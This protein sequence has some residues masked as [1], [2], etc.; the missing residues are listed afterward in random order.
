MKFKCWIENVDENTFFL[1]L[2]NVAKTKQWIALNRREAREFWENDGDLVDR[3]KIESPTELHKVQL[4]IPVDHV[5]G[6]KSFQETI[7]E[8]YNSFDIWLKETYKM[9]VV[10]FIDYDKGIVVLIKPI[11]F[12]I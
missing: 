2:V 11:K 9:N 3:W 6:L 1:Q 5:N 12:S 4:V 10:D 8:L 7:V